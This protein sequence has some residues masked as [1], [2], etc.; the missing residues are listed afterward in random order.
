MTDLLVINYHSFVD[1]ITNSSSELFVCDTKK[2][3]AQ[4]KEILKGLT[5]VYSVGIKDSEEATFYEEDDFLYENMFGEIKIA[6]KDARD[7]DEFVYADFY[8]DCYKKGDLLIFS[9]DDNTIPGPMF[10]MIESMF[11]ARRI[12]LG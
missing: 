1:V 12:H 3:V 11:D 6:E 9:A 7:D 4:V 5:L 2:T 10:E 8:G